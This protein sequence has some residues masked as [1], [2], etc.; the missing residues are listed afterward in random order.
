VFH[1]V[2]DTLDRA[3][4]QLLSGILERDHVDVMCGVIE[5]I[6]EHSEEQVKYILGKMCL[7]MLSY[8]EV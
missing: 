5:L 7:E 8:L 3:K 2:N 1:R 4:D 6:E